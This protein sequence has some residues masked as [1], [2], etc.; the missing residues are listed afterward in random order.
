MLAFIGHSVLLAI[1]LNTTY[2]LYRWVHKKGEFRQVAFKE[3]M[4]DHLEIESTSVLIEPKE[5]IDQNVDEIE[6]KVDKEDEENV[7]RANHFA[8][9]D[10]ATQTKVFELQETESQTDPPPM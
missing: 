10:R 4:I 1:L 7:K 9:L 8:F 2:L 3:K 5:S 6:E